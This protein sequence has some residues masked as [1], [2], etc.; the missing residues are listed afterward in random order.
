MLGAPRTITLFGRFRLL[1]R[2]DIARLLS[3]SGAR[4]NKDLTRRTDL[5]AV[6]SGALNLVPGG[7]LGRR[8]SAA[9]ERGVPVV[10][11]ARLLADL[12][13]EPRPE[14]TLDPGSVARVSPEL[15]ALL[16]AFD[17]VEMEGGKVRF[18]DADTLRT[19][20]DLSDQGFEPAAIL[21]TLKDRRNAPRGRHKLAVGADGTPVLEWEDGL[22]TLTGQGLLP[23]DEGDDLETLF[24]AAMEAEAAGLL[25][26]AARL[27]DTCARSDRKDA[28]APFN[29]GNVQTALGEADAAR[30]S[31]QRAIARQAN[32]PDAH[33]NLALALEAAG[34]TEGAKAHLETALRQDPDYAEALYNLA[35]LE[36]A[37]DR[38]D[39]ARR[40]FARFVEM[41]SA[42]PHLRDQAKRAVAVIE[43][44][45][46][47]GSP[48]G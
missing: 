8:L 19:A 26:E 45:G 29:L 20:A 22:T 31:Y 15:L 41:G 11:E 30:L 36:M 9:T 48:D 44:S 39:A 21:K 2:E 23:L 38:L 27:Y 37:A 24:D 3:A 42:E 1:P 28:I 13:E 43:R 46:F 40:H 47:S 6:G 33:H 18:Q 35:Q 14:A 34:D 5:L 7:S 4:Q 10:G 17:L 32:F 16:N 12:R 25:D